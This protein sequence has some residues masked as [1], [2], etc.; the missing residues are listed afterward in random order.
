MPA[1]VF[2]LQRWFAMPYYFHMKKLWY[3]VIVVAVIYL[4]W[5][6]FRPRPGV[7]Q[8]QTSTAGTIGTASVV[9]SVTG[10]SAA[11]DVAA[12]ATVPAAVTYSATGFSPAN[13]TIKK[14]E[15]VMWTNIS[16]GGMWVAAD[17]HPGHAGYDG[18]DRKT[19]CAAGAPSSFD[20]CV[21]SAAGSQ[22]SFTFNKVG[23]WKYHNHVGESFGGTVTVTE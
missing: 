14:G 9:D 7:M 2:F 18:T 22:W 5:E 19:H 1:A 15:A 6:F 4:G 13:I 23:T 17:E 11:G 10:G 20:Q 3:A 21:A 12:P 8:S 16:T